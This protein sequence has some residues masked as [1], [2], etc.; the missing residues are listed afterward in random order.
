MREQT[1]R[2]QKISTGFGTSTYH[3]FARSAVVREVLPMILP[4]LAEVSVTTCLLPLIN[5][6]G[7]AAVRPANARAAVAAGRRVENMWGPELS[8]CWQN[9]FI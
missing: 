8:R 9:N 4:M 5:W 6:L 3:L 1:K 7:R 2:K